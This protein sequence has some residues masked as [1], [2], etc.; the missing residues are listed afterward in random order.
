MVSPLPT[1]DAKCEKQFLVLV[2]EFP[3]VYHMDRL[4]GYGRG[5]KYGQCSSFI[6]NSLK[7]STTT[8]FAGLPDPQRRVCACSRHPLVKLGT[9]GEFHPKDRALTERRLHPNAATVHLNDLLRDSEPE[10]RT[11][12][13]LCV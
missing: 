4:G 11:A 7:I 9:D 10:T 12:F 1:G 13:G 5:S 3:E 2:T 6:T 8:F